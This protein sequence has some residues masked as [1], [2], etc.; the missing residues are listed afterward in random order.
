MIL[1]PIAGVQIRRVDRRVPPGCLERGVPGG[2]VDPSEYRRER[3]PATASLGYRGCRHRPELPPGRAR[4]R[5]RGRRRPIAGGWG[6]LLR[7]VPPGL[8]TSHSLRAGAGN[9]KETDSPGSIPPR[10]TAGAGTS[11]AFGMKE[12]PAKYLSG[13][14]VQSLWGRCLRRAG[15][16][17]LQPGVQPLPPVFFACPS[18]GTESLAEF[19]EAEFH[20][21]VPW[22]R[23]SGSSPLSPPRYFL[24]GGRSFLRGLA[25]FRVRPVLPYAI[26]PVPPPDAGGDH[27]GRG[28]GV[29]PS[30][31]REFPLA[32]EKEG[33]VEIE[34]KVWSK[35][36]DE[37]GG[38]FITIVHGTGK[39]QAPGRR[40]AILGTSF[41][42]PVHDQVVGRTHPRRGIG[43]KRE[44]AHRHQ[45]GSVRNA[46]RDLE[47]GI[48][49]DSSWSAPTTEHHREHLQGEGHPC[50]AGN[51]GRIR[52][53]RHGEGGIPVRRRFRHP[54]ARVRSDENGEEAL[55]RTSTS[56]R[57]TPRSSTSPRSR[58]DPRRAAPHRAGSQGTVGN[59]GGAD[60]D[61][62]HP[63]RQ[64][65]RAPHLVG[66]IGI[67]R[68]I[69]DPGE[70]QAHA[71][72]ERIRLNGMGAIVRTAAEGKTEAELKADMDYLVRH[73]DT[74]RKKGE[75]Q[76]RPPHPPGALPL[77]PGG[78]GPLHRGHGPDRRRLGGGVPR[79]REFASQFFPRLQ[80]RI[81]LYRGDSRSSNITASR[82]S[83]PGLSTR[84]SG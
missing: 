41:R 24:G 22:P 65:S 35:F 84:R 13:L 37:R 20:L 6:V 55:R 58:D 10:T 74:I 28:G 11:S 25:D 54:A 76:A 60:H 70:G 19:L 30:G 51:A 44:Q 15:S 78:T 33:Q 26:L 68:R 62:H 81:E 47:S 67:S 79:I 46:R 83:S 72:V 8:P 5:P 27:S 42:P 14:E 57:G 16:P 50:S 66:H 69:E 1:Q 64:V 40:G 56:M 38:L 39:A 61:P 3:H 63:S 32:V 18:R 48:L 9:K 45:F 17:G 36:L 80:D 73:W 59:Q 43:C 77:P 12:G 7:R 53:H 71:I 52:G 2:G 29:E 82:S 49:V 75:A 31:I 34:L 21:P 23:S 4:K